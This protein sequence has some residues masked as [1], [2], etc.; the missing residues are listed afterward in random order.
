M[1]KN[2]IITETDHE[3]LT[4]MVES[5]R[6]SRQRDLKHLDELERELDSAVVVRSGE[7]PRDVVTMNSRV[8]V[9]DLNTGR[10]ITY[11]IVFPKDADVAQNRISVLAP[12]GTGL[13]GH[14]AGSIVEWDVP[15]GTRCFRI[16]AVEYQPEAAGTA[17]SASE[18]SRNSAPGK[19]KGRVVGRDDLSI[20]REYCPACQTIYLPAAGCWC[21]GEVDQSRRHLRP[22]A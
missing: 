7:V 22:V 5:S 14:S 20:E 19:Q 1:R 3:R 9:K 8:R 17:A 2:I 12:I 10:E 15:S 11:Q 21:R 4:E 6:R 13:L 18:Q 16:L